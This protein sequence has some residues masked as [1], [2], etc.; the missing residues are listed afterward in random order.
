MNRAATGAQMAVRVTFV[1]QI[2]LG[3]AFWTGHLSGLVPVHIAS[4]VILVLGLWVLAAL[5]AQSGAPI[6]QVIA[7]GVW[8]AVVILFGLTHDGIL[9]GGWHWLIQV[10]HLLL[11]LGA[12]GQA[13]ALGG[14]IRQAASPA[15]APVATS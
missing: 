6:G 10:F 15:P 1:I 4:G 9:T 8:G 3:V 2:V 11:G 13:E 14:R 7:A 12:I 5:G